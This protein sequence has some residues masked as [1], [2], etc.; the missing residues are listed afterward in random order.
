MTLVGNTYLGIGH[1]LV[2]FILGFFIYI[3]VEWQLKR[4]CEIF[5]I[6]PFLSHDEIIRKKYE[7][8]KQ[9]QT[10]LGKTQ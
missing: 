8:D 7:E 2:T 6:L 3:L 5:I 4:F 9:S 1:L 10:K